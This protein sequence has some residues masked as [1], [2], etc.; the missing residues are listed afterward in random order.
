MKQSLPYHTL[1]ES[2][3]AITHGI[4]VLLSCIGLYLLILKGISISTLALITYC[5]YGTTLIILYLS[6]TLYHSFSQTTARSVL[7]RIDHASIFLLIAGTYTPYTLITVRGWFGI[8]STTLIWSF[9]LFGVVYKVWWFKQFQGM[10]TALYIGMGWISLGLMYHLYQGLGIIG[11]LWL[12]SGGIAFTVG[13][14]FYRLKHLRYTHV[15]WHLFVLLGTLLM[16]A[17][18][19]Y[20]T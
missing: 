11:V 6:S 17:S 12:A 5:I 15:V 16:F 2:L 3:N 8:T 14:L 18:I 4:G 20:Y 13:T 19:Y 1:N 9:A 10:S 7:Q